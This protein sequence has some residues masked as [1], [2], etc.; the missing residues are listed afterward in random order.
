MEP[1]KFP[2]KF[3]NDHVS[4]YLVG[5]EKRPIADHV[6]GVMLNA[7]TVNPNHEWFQEYKGIK[8]MDN[9]IF[10]GT[11]L[12][13]A[14]LAE[15]ARQVQPDIVVGPDVL[16]DDDIHIKSVERQKRFMKE[17]LPE[18]TKVQLVPQGNTTEHYEWCISQIVKMNPDYI[19]LGRM[20]MKLAGYPLKGHFQRVYAL[21]RFEELGLLDEIRDNAIKIHALGISKPSEFKY[22]N[23]FSVSCADSMSYIY[24][25][26]YNQI[27]WPGDNYE[28]Q[29]KINKDGSIVRKKTDT[30]EVYEAKQRFFATYPASGPL[31]ERQLWIIKNVWLP[32]RAELATKNHIREIVE[33][34]DFEK[35]KDD[36]PIL[37]KPNGKKA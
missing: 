16:Y 27:V 33:G 36:T 20:S 34:V 30:D 9:G 28:G 14:E 12:S 29:T 31:D 1:N 8:V 19:G 35:E 7:V 3:T 6:E 10:G 5:A 32:C 11:V 2:A 18:R 15:K 21:N 17:K 26:I 37:E 22:L 4:L 23:Y 25:S 24:S 13:V